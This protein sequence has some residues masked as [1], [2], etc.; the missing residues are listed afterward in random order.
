MI[1]VTAK[2]GVSAVRVS[3]GRNELVADA[4][5]TDGGR[6]DGFKPHDLIEAALASCIALTLRSYLERHAVDTETLRVVAKLD[7]SAAGHSV[8]RYDFG[9]GGAPLSPAIASALPRVAK[10]C[11]VHKTLTRALEIERTELVV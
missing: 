7:L 9:I 8:Q 3:D 11:P 2:P 6:G 5:V 4:T 10:A 1:T